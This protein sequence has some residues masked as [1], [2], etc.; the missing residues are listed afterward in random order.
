MGARWDKL[1][2][3]IN[4]FHSQFA[5]GGATNF[6]SGFGD[7]VPAGPKANGHLVGLYSYLKDLGIMAELAAAVGDKA[8]MENA[9]AQ[10]KVVADAFNAAFFDASKGCYG[11]CLQTENSMALWLNIVP[12]EHVDA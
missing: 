3:Y 8:V 4:F 1:K 6:M 5:K 12:D 11:T 2:S 7:W 9:T 10:R